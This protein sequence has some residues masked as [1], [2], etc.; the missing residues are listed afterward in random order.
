VISNGLVDLSSF[1]RSLD[2]APFLLGERR[3]IE[4]DQVADA[5]LAERI[6]DS[7]SA[8]WLLQTESPTDRFRRKSGP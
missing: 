1:E 3:P 4:V 6:I 8:V 5:K 2:A 7:D